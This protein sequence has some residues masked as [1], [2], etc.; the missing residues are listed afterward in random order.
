M[1]EASHQDRRGPW[2]SVAGVCV[3]ATIGLA[4]FVWAY[5]ALLGLDHPLFMF[6]VHFVSM[7]WAALVLQALKPDLDR[8]WFEPK[9]FERGGKI[10]RRLGVLWWQAGARRIGWERITRGRGARFGRGRESAPERLRGSRFGETAHLMGIAVTLPLLVWM[11]VAREWA[12]AGY[13]VLWTVLLRVYPIL[14]QRHHRPRYARV[15]AW[16]ARRRASGAGDRTGE[17]HER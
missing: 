10:Y 1:D 9:R 7:G 6:C 8:A 11:I 16:E 14:L 12:A 3:G 2:W 13:F 15:V 4:A 17:G 5:V